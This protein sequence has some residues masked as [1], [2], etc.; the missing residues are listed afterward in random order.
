MDPIQVAYDVNE[1]QICVGRKFCHADAEK[2]ID[3]TLSMRFI[4]WIDEDDFIALV[5]PSIFLMQQLTDEGY[6]EIDTKL[7]TINAE[8]P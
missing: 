4:E 6:I 8:M 2:D 1:D 7:G 3:A 5:L